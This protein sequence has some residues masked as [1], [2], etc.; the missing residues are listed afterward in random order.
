MI[1]AET[2]TGSRWL[3][4]GA[5]NIDEARAMLAEPG[6]VGAYLVLTGASAGELGMVRAEHVVSIAPLPTAPR[7]VRK[8]TSIADRL[9]GGSAA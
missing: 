8:V 5:T 7:P 3:L 4:A 9:P 6:F 2:V 1:L